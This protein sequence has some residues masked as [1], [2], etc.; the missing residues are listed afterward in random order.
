VTAA[1]E[2]I[3]APQKALGGQ[4]PIALARTDLGAREVEALVDRLEQG[5]IV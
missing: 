5:V 4:R 1:R 3:S 2:W